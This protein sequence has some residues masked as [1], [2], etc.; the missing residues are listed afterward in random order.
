MGMCRENTF[1]R[2][3]GSHIEIRVGNNALHI[4]VTKQF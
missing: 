1:L 2:D 4:N 3:L